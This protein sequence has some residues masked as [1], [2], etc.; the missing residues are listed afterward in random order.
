MYKVTFVGLVCFLKR[1]DGSRLALMPDGR[2]FNGIERHVLRLF[3]RR[4]AVDRQR[5]AGFPVEE[6]LRGVFSLPPSRIEITGSHDPTVNLDAA[7]HDAVIPSL[8]AID[9]HFA[10]DPNTARTVGK[11][12][13]RQGTLKAYRHPGAASTIDPDISLISQLRV[14]YDA[15]ITIDVI[16]DDGTP[17]KTIALQPSTEILIA[18]ASMPIAPPTVG[19][20]HFEIYAQLANGPVNLSHPVFSTIGPPPLFSTNPYWSVTGG[21]GLHADCSN[22][23]CCP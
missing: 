1:P 19:P 21:I 2:D 9:P 10:I 3:V 4:T 17:A 5:T 15:A 12:E 7:G 8:V 14:D 18:N 6:I 13:I 11:L 16:P 22:T 20:Q 23:G